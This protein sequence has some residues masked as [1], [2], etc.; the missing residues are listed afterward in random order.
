MEQPSHTVFSRILK[1]A[2]IEL[3]GTDSY[4][5]FVPADGTAQNAS[6]TGETGIV[7]LFASYGIDTSSVESIKSNELLDQVKGTSLKP[8]SH[9]SKSIALLLLTKRTDT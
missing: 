5:V 8:N 3:N 2:S 1:A 7:G 6:V 4:T 9:K